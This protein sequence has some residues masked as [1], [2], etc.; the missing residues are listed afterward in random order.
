MNAVMRWTGLLLTAV[1]AGC[2]GEPSSTA[3]SPTPGA[4][5]ATLV[6]TPQSAPR[7]RSWDGVVEAVNQA[8]L[9]AQTGGRVIEL[10][11][12]VNDFVEAGEVI[13]RFTDVEQQSMQRQAQAALA[14]AQAAAAEADTAFKRIEEIY[15]RQLVPRAQYDEAL[16]RRDSARAQL[17]AARAGA[18][19]SGEQVDYTVIRAPYTGIV[20]ERHVELGET[21]QPGQPLM[22]GLS[23]DRLRVVVDVPQGEVA[24]IRRHAEAAV[25]LADGRR[26]PASEVIVFPFADPRTH[27]FR[28]RVEL[29]EAATG[30]H[31]GM[32]VKTAFVIGSAERLLVPVSALLQ[33]SELTAVYVVDDDGR[34]GL[35]QIRPGHRFGDEIEVLAGLEAGERIAVDPLAALAALAAEADR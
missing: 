10:P 18:R 12:D 30:L 11:F 5:L 15:R 3:R 17:E 31:P 22:S 9:S 21:V 34:V 4:D 16:A 27:S 24:A 35:R 6:V 19:Q 25:L 28:V 26:I 2:G 29:D 13:I 1:L 14:A 7:E 33:R 8:T 32:T 20:T 23:L